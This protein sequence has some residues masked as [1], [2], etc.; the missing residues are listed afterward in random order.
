M[1]QYFF[2]RLL[3][4]IPTL[5]GILLI[6]FIIIQAAPGG[7][8]QHVLSMMRG[9]MSDVDSKFGSEDALSSMS[10]Q[11]LDNTY[12][13]SDGIDPAFIKELEKQ[14]GFD[15]PAYERFFQMIKN[16]VHFDFGVSYFKNEKVADMILS[17]LPVS[18]S[19]GLWT[20]LIVHLIAIPL[21]VTKAIQHGSK[22]DMVTSS[23]VIIAYAVPSF[24]FALFLM[25]LF[26]G[27]GLFELF[28]LRGLFSVDSYTY[29]TWGKICDYAWH[30]VLPITAMSLNGIAKITFLTKNIFMEEMHKQYVLTAKSLGFSQ[31]RV[32]YGHIFRNAMI[33]IVASS[34]NTLIAV[35]FTTSLLTEVLF[36]LDGLGLL[37]FESALC[38]DFPVMFASLY[39]FT[40]IG[41]LLHLLGDFCLMFI[42]KRIDLSKRRA[43]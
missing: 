26:A 31:N 37:A 17:K 35:L 12:S 4:M 11:N 10:D 25:S 33:V 28:P 14:F 6:N 16:Y 24:L 23:V 1:L 9:G 2:K 41:M 5:F 15:K 18:I 3:L 36:S 21:G 40:I 42:D 34:P 38:R 27:G 7:P 30:L 19:L 13:G 43:S 8:I 39:I 20:M 29:S 22:F 32:L